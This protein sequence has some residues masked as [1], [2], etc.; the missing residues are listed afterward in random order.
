MPNLLFGFHIPS[1]SFP[2]A[3]PS[4]LFDRVVSLAVAAEGANFDMVT[5][6]DHFYQIANVGPETEPMLEAYTTLGA[7][8]QRTRRVTLAT[9][10]TGVTYRNPALVAKQVTTLD[11]LS[12]GRAIL[13]IGAAWNGD[14]HQGYGFEFPP[15]GRRLDRLGE[16]LQIVRK[17]FTEDRPSFAGKYYSIDRALNVPRPIQPGGPRIMVGGGGEQRTL[18]LV[19]RYADI[20]NWFGSVEDARRKGDLLERYCAEVD[21]EPS[22]ITRTMM[23]PILLVTSHKEVDAVTQMIPPER[24]RTLIGPVTPEQAADVLAPYLAVGIAGF[25]FSNVNLHNPELIAAAGELKTLL[26]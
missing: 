25:T 26:S 7:L 5:V 14:E 6:M 23:A 21:R 1:F 24:L 17:M 2:G 22:E 16:A 12:G 15:V 11:I 9:L 18:R 20:S 4:D 19:A 8:S 3:A 10:V 13:G